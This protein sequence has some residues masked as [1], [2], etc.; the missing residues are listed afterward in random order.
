MSYGFQLQCPDKASAKAAV[1][2]KIAEIIT[3]QAIHARDEAA[4]LANANAVIDL[5]HDDAEKDVHVSCN[6]YVSWSNGADVAAA[7][8]SSVKIE[9]YAGHVARAPAA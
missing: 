1:S 6:G 4:I 5:L 2:A 8:F 9:C 3:H 7:Q